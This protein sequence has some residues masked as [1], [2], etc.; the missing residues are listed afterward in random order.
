MAELLDD[1]DAIVVD[2]RN[3]NEREAGHIPGTMHIPLGQLADRAD[4]LP[5]DKTI[6]LHCQG[7]TRAAIG[8]SVLQSLGFDQVLHVQGGYSEW[9]RTHPQQADP[10]EAGV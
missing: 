10:S 1:D 8:A 5:R 3:A 7:G 4:E 9:S 2:L 6:A